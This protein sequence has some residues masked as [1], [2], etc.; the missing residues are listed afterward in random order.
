MADQTHFI[1]EWR[2][3]RGLTQVQFAERLGINQGH[4]SK[5]ESGARKYDQEFLELAAIEL[6]CTPGDLIIRNPTD[7]EGIW[8]IWDQ[9]QPVQR[10]QLLEIG[11]TLKTGT[12]G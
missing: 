1:R 9:L 8:T 12:G 11:K 4:L 7:P 6:R 10:Q 2:K 5:I 3:H